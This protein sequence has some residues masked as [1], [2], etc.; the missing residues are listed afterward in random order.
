MRTGDAGLF[1]GDGQLKI[2][3]RARDVGRLEEGALFAPKFIENKLKFY[4]YIKEAVAFG[5]G[6]PFVATFINIDL[7]AVGDWAGRRGLAYASYQELT[8][9][10][11]VYNLIEGASSRSTGI[12][13]PSPRSPP[14][15]F[16]VF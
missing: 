5:D 16:A 12:L 3:D 6:R 14:R 8:A 10:E 15:R 2:L 7:E 4:P 13:P 9:E 11:A 1:D